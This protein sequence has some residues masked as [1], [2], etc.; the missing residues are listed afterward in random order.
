[1]GIK[2]KFWELEGLRKEGQNARNKKVGGL[3]CKVGVK[4]AVTINGHT[5]RRQQ[6]QIPA[7]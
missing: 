7:V 3:N 1:M 5:G 2:C 6:K 4:P